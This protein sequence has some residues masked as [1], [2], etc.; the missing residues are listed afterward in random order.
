MKIY[1]C[2]ICGNIIEK[3]E[4]DM[5]H[6]TCCGKPMEEIVANT[7]DAATEKHVPVYE[8]VGNE[9]IVKV[10]EIEHPMQEEHYIT[11][12]AQVSKNKIEKV[13]LKPGDEPKA[14][15]TYIP[16]ATIYAFC[17]LHGLWKTDIK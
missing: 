4:G 10:G 1:K 16:N 17:N 15:F 11:W 12:I 7:V 9:I 8:K 13:Y 6:I 14:K 2:S 3:I 5:Q